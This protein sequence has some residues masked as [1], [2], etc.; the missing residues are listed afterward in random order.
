MRK[1]WLLL[2]S[3]ALASPAFAQGGTGFGSF[4][5]FGTDLTEQRPANRGVFRGVVRRVDLSRGTVTIAAG[6]ELA[7]YH[8]TPLQI[9]SVRPGEQVSGWYIRLE[10]QMW[11]MG[12]ADQFGTGLGDGFGDVGALGDGF[13][14]GAF[15]GGIGFGTTGDIPFGRMGVVTG[16]VNQVDKSGGRLIVSTSG[17]PRTFRAH[18]QAIRRILPGQYLSV[19]FFN[20]GRV[21]WVNAYEAGGTDTFGGTGTFGTFGDGFGGF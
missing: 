8:A 6:G 11:V 18:P 14:D 13:G 17:G 10:D 12:S 19:Q 4:G 9:A 15:V 2:G 21:S 5:T 1:M 7:T 20:V 3:L 16:T